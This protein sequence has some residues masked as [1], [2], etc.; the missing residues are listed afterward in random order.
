MRHAGI[1]GANVFGQVIEIIGVTR[2]HPLHAIGK[3]FR[4]G[5]IPG[6]THDVGGQ[7]TCVL[8][9]CIKLVDHLG[10]F[11]HLFQVLIQWRLAGDKKAGIPGVRTNHERN[12]RLFALRK[13]R[14]RVAL[15]DLAFNE[16]ATKLTRLK[17]G[18]SQ[19]KL[20]CGKA[21]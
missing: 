10:I 18:R 2:R 9:F 6:V 17:F 13:Q 21:S 14:N 19:L 20:G 3:H 16:S 8:I 7:N 15:K 5:A 12:P 11:T 1:G 4:G